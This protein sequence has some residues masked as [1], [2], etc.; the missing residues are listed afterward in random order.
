MTPWPG[1]PPFPAAPDPGLEERVARERRRTALWTVG[2]VL[3]ALLVLAP[4]LAVPWLVITK[5]ALL[6]HDDS[7]CELVGSTER[8]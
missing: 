8:C 6:D 5:G 1:L 4:I 7:S 3:L 2:A